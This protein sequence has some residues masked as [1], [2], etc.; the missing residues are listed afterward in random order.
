MQHLFCLLADCNG[1]DHR[2]SFGGDGAIVIGRLCVGTDSIHNVHA[3]GHI[4]ESGI[5]AV[6]EGGVLVDDEELGTGTVGIL[7][8]GH[9]NGAAGVRDR[10]F[11]AVLAEL[12]F[13]LGVAFICQQL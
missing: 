4:A 9:G 11:M 1:R 3:F 6:Q 2:L 12:T 7:G 8:A 10:I 5:L 13:D